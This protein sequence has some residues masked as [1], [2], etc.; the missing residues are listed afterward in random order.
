MVRYAILGPVEFCDGER[1]VGV[2][3]PRQVALLALLLVNANHA[4]VQ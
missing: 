1:R 3:G 4:G 2:G